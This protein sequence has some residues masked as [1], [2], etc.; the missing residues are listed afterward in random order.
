VCYALDKI[1]SYHYL[2]YNKELKELINLGKR[3]IDIGSSLAADSLDAPNNQ[4][5]S[6][7]MANTGI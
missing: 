4:A 3:L 7:A 6:K 2:T 5:L 1:D